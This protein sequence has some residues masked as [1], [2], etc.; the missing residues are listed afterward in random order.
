MWA[1]SPVWWFLCAGSWVFYAF[2]HPLNETTIALSSLGAF[3]AIMAGIT[4]LLV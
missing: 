2:K 1:A 4:L 3:F